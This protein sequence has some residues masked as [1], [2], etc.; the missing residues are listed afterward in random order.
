MREAMLLCDTEI[1]HA[2]LIGKLDQVVHALKALSSTMISM[3]SV[4]DGINTNRSAENTDFY[5]AQK[6]AGAW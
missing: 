5:I 2:E 3:S 6:R 4:L 1:R